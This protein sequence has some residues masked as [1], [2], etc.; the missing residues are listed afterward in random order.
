MDPTI[1][2]PL[3]EKGSELAGRILGFLSTTSKEDQRWDQVLQHVDQVQHNQEV[4]ELLVNA[5]SAA[6]LD[7]TSE[8]RAQVSTGFG[9]VL[10]GINQILLK[11][12]SSQAEVLLAKAEKVTDRL[13]LPKP[14]LVEITKDLIDAMNEYFDFGKDKAFFLQLPRLYVLFFVEYRLCRAT[15]YLSAAQW[16]DRKARYRDSVN[17]ATADPD[18]TPGGYNDC[19][20]AIALGPEGYNAVEQAFYQFDRNFFAQL[21]PPPDDPG[22]K[23]MDRFH[24]LFKAVNRL[25]DAKDQGDRFV[26]ALPNLTVQ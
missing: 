22:V 8:L 9:Q 12:D 10:N 2:V 26:K 5:R 3:V 25:R 21:F 1:V 11:Q 15:K 23:G 4:I 14:D 19:A 18:N 16:D 6:I 13:D 7:E 17:R 24:S 20:Q